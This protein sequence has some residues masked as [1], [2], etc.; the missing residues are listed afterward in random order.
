MKFYVSEEGI[1]VIAVQDEDYYSAQERSAT[2]VHPLNT[3]V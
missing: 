3:P 2:P 1:A